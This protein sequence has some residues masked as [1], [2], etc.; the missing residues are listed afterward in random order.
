MQVPDSCMQVPN[1]LVHGDPHVPNMS[2]KENFEKKLFYNAPLRH[3]PMFSAVSLE[4]IINSK[5]IKKIQ[6]LGILVFL[7]KISCV[8]KLR[9]F[10]GGRKNARIPGGTIWS[11]NFSQF[12][13]KRE[14]FHHLQITQIFLYMVTHMRKTCVCKKILKKIIL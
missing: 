6:K 14:F 4:G 3:R 2:M 1:Y 10:G 11:F 13:K 7:W 8:P 12:L 9:W 5:K